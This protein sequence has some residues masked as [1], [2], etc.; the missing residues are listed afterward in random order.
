[1]RAL[2]TFVCATKMDRRPAQIERQ[3]ATAALVLI[4]VLMA[5][6]VAAQSRLEPQFAADPGATGTATGEM[7]PKK[8]DA[9]LRQPSGPAARLPALQQSAIAFGDWVLRCEPTGGSNACALH[10]RLA[11]SAGRKIITFKVAGLDDETYLEVSAPLG[12][13]IP[14]GVAL[15]LPDKTILP[16]QLADCDRAGC[17]AVTPLEN[18]KLL[19]QKGVGRLGVR[20][21]DSKTGKVVTVRGSLVGFTEGVD[22]LRRAG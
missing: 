1:M 6:P 7:A 13:S 8:A 22:A 14:Y 15:V 18:G 12:I 4:A 10:Q 19:N 20:F 2:T 3:P 5:P 16:M 21:Q 9:A 17:R 11:D